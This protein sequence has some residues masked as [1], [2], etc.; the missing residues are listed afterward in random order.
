MSYEPPAGDPN[1]PRYDPQPPDAPRRVS[2]SDNNS[3]G[4]SRGWMV[5][6]VALIALALGVGGGL[7]IDSGGGTTKT[8]RTGTKTVTVS[9]NSVGVTV[10]QP[11]TT[12]T[13]TV[14]APPET[15][16]VTVPDAATETETTG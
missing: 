13:Q 8:V 2:D 15:V 7:L 16:T 5:A 1:D 11:T 3:G 12:V 10:R 9:T 4:G 14:T 6:T